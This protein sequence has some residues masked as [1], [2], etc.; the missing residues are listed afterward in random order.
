MKEHPGKAGAKILQTVFVT[1]SAGNRVTAVIFNIPSSTPSTN[2]LFAVVNDK[3][4]AFYPGQRYSLYDE[5]RLWQYNAA[6]A[7]GFSRFQH[8][9]ILPSVT[10]PL[11]AA[12]IH[13]IF[14]SAE[15]GN[16][17]SVRWQAAPLSI[18]HQLCLNPV[19]N[20]QLTLI[21]YF[22]TGTNENNCT[23]T[24]HGQPSEPSP[25]VIFIFPLP[26]P[27]TMITSTI[28]FISWAVKGSK[29]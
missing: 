4:L 17:Q 26:L 25:L 23:D 14:T 2:N 5:T 15:G 1:P 12:V 9:S 27:P 24:G 18:L 10:P 21:R 13:Q 19:D 7:N 6:V 22:A 16:L 11:K 3:G 20:P 8:L 28:F 29:S